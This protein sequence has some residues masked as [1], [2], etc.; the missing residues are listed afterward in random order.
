MIDDPS[1][2]RCTSAVFSIIVPTCGCST[3]RMPLAAAIPLMR[4]RLSSKRLPALVV[5]L[6]AAVVA[7]WPLTADSTSVEAFDAT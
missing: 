4:L 2:T 1:S 3:A 5:E 6:G 7:V